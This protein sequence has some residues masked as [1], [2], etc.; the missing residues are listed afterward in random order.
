MGYWNGTGLNQLS[1]WISVRWVKEGNGAKV[2]QRGVNWNISPLLNTDLFTGKEEASRQDAVMLLNFYLSGPAAPVL[3][4]KPVLLCQ[5]LNTRR[6]GQIVWRK[7]KRETAEAL[8][9]NFKWNFTLFYCVVKETF[10]AHWHLIARH[11]VHVEHYT[12]T[13]A[14]LDVHW[15]SLHMYSYA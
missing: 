12:S 2:H 15:A 10:E 14:P 11:F 7:V 5:F 6:K 9:Q 8:K 1:G 4:H 3:A 13:K